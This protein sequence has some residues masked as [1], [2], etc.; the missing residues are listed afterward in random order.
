MS[1]LRTVNTKFWDD[2][3]IT[4]LKPD[5]KLLFLYLLTNPL[6]NILGI[7]EITLRRISY[8]TG[9]KSERVETI[10]VENFMVAK[11]VFWMKNYIVLP[12]FLKNQHLNPAMQKGAMRIFDDLPSWL[13]DSILDEAPGGYQSLRDAILNINR[14]GIEYEVEYEDEDESKPFP[15]ETDNSGGSRGVSTNNDL[16]TPGMFDKFLRMYPRKVGKGE[17]LTKWKT[18]C[19]RKKHERPS[20]AT[21][22]NAIFEQKQTEQWSN[23]EFIPYPATWLNQRRW[24]N[25]PKTMVKPTQFNRDAPAASRGAKKSRFDDFH[26]DDEPLTA[27]Q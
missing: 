26:S 25:D 14:I 23:K 3:F 11:K 6:T 16:I 20:W 1:K 13:K 21:I 18:I 2:P 7:Y 27:R 9:I 24:L 12:N 5:E 15:E 10:L 8:D 17:A 19:K 4:K 22:R